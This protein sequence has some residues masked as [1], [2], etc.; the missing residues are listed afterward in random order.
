MHILMWWQIDRAHG[1]L[2]GPLLRSAWGPQRTNADPDCRHPKH[3]TNSC[4]HIQGALHLRQCCTPVRTDN[5]QKHATSEPR[6][7]HHQHCAMSCWLNFVTTLI[8][9]LFSLKFSQLTSPIISFCINSCFRFQF[10]FNWHSIE[11]NIHPIHSPPSPNLPK[12]P[13][14]HSKL[15]WSSTEQHGHDLW[16]LCCY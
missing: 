3:V 2:T 1:D 8:T 9:M 15:S 7:P 5:T 13:W 16:S 6:I 14:P 4:S 12:W 11:I 10:W